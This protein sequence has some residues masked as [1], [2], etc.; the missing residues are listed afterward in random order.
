ML[1][2]TRT[3]KEETEG[4]VDARVVEHQ[5]NALLLAVPEI[6]V[7]QTT[8]KLQLAATTIFDTDCN[9]CGLTCSTILLRCVDVQRKEDKNQ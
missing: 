6:V 5:S 7:F 8:G 4:R 1:E 9:H 2:Y 3:R